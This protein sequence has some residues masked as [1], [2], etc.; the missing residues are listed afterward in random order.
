MDEQGNRLI[1]IARLSG[2]SIG[3]VDRVIHDRGK[4]SESARIRVVKAISSLNYKPNL[5]AR[6]L[7]LKTNLLI[8]ILIPDEPLDEYWNTVIDGINSEIGNWAHYGIKIQFY[9]YPLQPAEQLRE[10]LEEYKSHNPGG[11]IL[12]PVNYE[13]SIDLLKWADNNRIPYVLFDSNVP[14]A[15]PLSFI[16]QDLVASGRLAA[17][18]ILKTIPRSGEIAILHIDEELGQAPYLKRKES[19]FMELF[20]GS[21]YNL[22]VYALHPNQPDTREKIKSIISQPQLSALFVTTSR[23]TSIVADILESENRKD[24]SFVGYDLLKENV[25]HLKNDVISF[26]INQNPRLMARTALSY[27]LSSLVFKKE[28]PGEEFYPLDVIT[29]ENVDSYLLFQQHNR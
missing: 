6:S 12:A 8:S 24:L 23:A 1:D 14:E 22:S 18:L 21:N 2:V 27:L 7:R 15:C 3:T 11:F 13:I 4:V 25:K 28:I 5:L 19:G 29:K 16:G 10:K 17:E 20:A 26:L 9:L